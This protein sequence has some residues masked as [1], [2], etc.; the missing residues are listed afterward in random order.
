M[1]HAPTPQNPDRCKRLLAA[2]SD[3]DWALVVRAYG[4]L[5]EPRSLLSQK[6]KRDLRALNWATDKFL[7]EHA[8]LRFR[9]FERPK[10]RA[11][12]PQGPSPILG[13]E[14][15]LKR[16]LIGSDEFVMELLRDPDQPRKAREAAMQR[17]AAV[18]ENA[19]RT[20]P[21]EASRPAIVLNGAPQ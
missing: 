6:E 14:E 16:R 15:E 2:I 20:P 13:A 1:E 12:R 10:I 7:T 5:Q 9:I 3:E 17:W 8:Y 21:W 19:S 4:R 11:P 18:P